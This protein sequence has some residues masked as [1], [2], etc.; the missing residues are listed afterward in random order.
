MATALTVTTLGGPYATALT[1]LTMGAADPTGNYV[2]SLN[3]GDILIFH[4]SG[5]SERTI[6]I[7]SVALNGRTGDITAATIAAGIYKVFG[8]FELEG[9]AQTTGRLNITVNNAEVLVGVLRR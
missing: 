5:A 6:T 3:R 2:V 9:W 4:N 8:P 7:S 1:A